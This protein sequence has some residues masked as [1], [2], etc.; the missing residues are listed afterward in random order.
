M[1]RRSL[2]RFPFD[3]V[4]LPYNF[5]QMQDQRYASEFEALAG[6]CR[7]RGVA[8]QTIKSIALAPWDG[9]PQTTSTW[10]EPLR[11]PAD[12]ELAV[13]W[14]MGR[15]DVFL[16]TASDVDLL[17]MVLAAADSFQD[18]P[19]HDAM[20]SLVDRRSLRPLFV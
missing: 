15:P 10:Y 19:D 14:V 20:Q 8:M 18:R 4:L 17:P 13:H 7:E 3:S 5:T 1:H 12:I 9:R 2:E 16:N 6:I 11:D